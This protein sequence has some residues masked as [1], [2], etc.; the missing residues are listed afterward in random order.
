MRRGFSFH[1]L[2]EEELHDAA[3]Y[4]EHVSPR[5][6]AAFLEEVERAI[7]QVLEFPEST[8]EVG[9]GVRRKLIRRFPYS[10]LYSIREH[11]LRI[12]AVM[13]QRR[14]PFYWRGRK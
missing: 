11:D 12:L 3:E 10:L 6:G 14:R 7:R 1:L 5:L 8:Q 9:A 13:N 2:A 4:Y